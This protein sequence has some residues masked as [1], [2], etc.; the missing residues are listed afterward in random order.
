VTGVLEG[1]A[2]IGVVVAL[3]F[4]LAHLGVLDVTAQNVLSRL[5][6]YVA[7]PALLVVVMSRT[8]IRAI[9]SANLVSSFASVVVTVVVYLAIVRWRSRPP[10]GEAV[11]G[12]LCA[13]YVNA[14]NLGLPIALYVLGDISLMAR[15]RCSMPRPAAS[16][17]RWWSA[18]S[19]SSATPSRPVP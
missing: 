11:I 4:L 14:G 18:S 2:T 19:G 5:T 12:S 17:Q 8:P 10:L 1:F 13:A 7:S 9:L 15:W 3:G 6:F 16:D